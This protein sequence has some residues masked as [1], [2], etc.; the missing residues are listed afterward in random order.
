MLLA[1]LERFPE[2]RLVV[3]EVFGIWL[4]VACIRWHQWHINHLLAHAHLPV[5]FLLLLN[6]IPAFTG[7]LHHKCLIRIDN[8]LYVA[9]LESRC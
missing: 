2:L 3:C 7:L 5:W 1:Y 9:S 4:L 8:D 6:V